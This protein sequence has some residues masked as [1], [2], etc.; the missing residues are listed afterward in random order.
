MNSNVRK[1][2]GIGLFCAIVVVL[3]Y[4]FG[5][6]TVGGTSINPVLVP[7]VVG[8]AVY[9]WQAGAILGFVS[10][11]AILLITPPS[12]FYGISVAGTVVTVLA[13]GTLSGLAAGIVY[14]LLCRRSRFA[15]VLASAMVCPVVNT[16]LFLAG[17]Y[18]FFYQGLLANAGGSFF[19]YLITT[20]VGL[21]I[22][23][24]LGINMVMAPVITRLIK[25]GTN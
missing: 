9:G 6:I 21:N 15:A 19:G 7:V 24:E 18:L 25:I 5:G 3:Q 14:R 22:F 11:V 16:G 20:M 4:L 17:C 8:A 10:G 12:F 13:K 23:V 1:T 2:V